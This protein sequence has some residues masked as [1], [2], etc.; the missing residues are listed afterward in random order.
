[1]FPALGSNA[2]A[3]SLDSYSNT[4]LRKCKRKDRTG[5]PGLWQLMDTG[6]QSLDSSQ[7]HP[8]KSAQPG[9]LI[10][11]IVHKVAMP[12]MRLGCGVITGISVATFL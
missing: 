4:V 3:H 5:L 2:S 7:P 12:W 6:V 8:P 10:A 11:A 9:Q 1:M